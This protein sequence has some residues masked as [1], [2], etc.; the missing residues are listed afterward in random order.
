M[1]CEL[2]FRKVLLWNEET[3]FVNRRLWNKDNQTIER[4]WR[5]GGLS[6]ENYNW[7]KYYVIYLQIPLQTFGGAK[8][9][10]CCPPP[11]PPREFVEFI[12]CKKT[13]GIR[14]KFQKR[15]MPSYPFYNFKEDSWTCDVSKPYFKHLF[16]K[17]QHTLFRIAIYLFRQALFL[18]YILKPKH[19]V[20]QFVPLCI[21][22]QSWQQIQLVN[23][24]RQHV[25]AG[26]S[27]SLILLF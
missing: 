25:R 10:Y 8:T 4:M 13:T 15:G 2:I 3:L 24:I 26:P 19:I 17:L 20:F 14:G 22:F 7:K 11:P 16:L 6:P 12:E 21:N 1:N 27:Y 18:N 9:Q 23:S 5:P